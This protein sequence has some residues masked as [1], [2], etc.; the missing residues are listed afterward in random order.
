[1][2][3]ARKLIQQAEQLPFVAKLAFVC[4]LGLLAFDLVVLTTLALS[5]STKID[6]GLAT[7]VAAVAG[8]GI[9]AWQTGKGFSNLIRSQEN[10]AVIEREARLHRAELERAA[11]ERKT[12]QDKA[13]LLGALRAETAYLFGEVSNAERHV[14]GL[15]TIQKALVHRGLPPTAKAL[16]LHTFD[17][18]VFKANISKLGLLGAYLGADII[19]VLS[20]ANGKEIKFTLDQPFPHEVSFG[21]H[22]Y[23]KGRAGNSP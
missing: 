7:L 14:M 22:L 11:E 20:K 18:P 8:F 10:Q 4:S 2:S 5:A 15:V 12:E 23:A 16:A 3:L 6:P 17:A 9:I 19:K 21:L 13:A 1:M